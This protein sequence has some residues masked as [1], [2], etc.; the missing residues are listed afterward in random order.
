MPDNTFKTLGFGTTAIHA[1]QKPDPQY[2]ALA[3]P[4]YQTSTFCFSTVEEGAKKFAHELPGYVYSRG[5]NPTTAALQEKIAIL[6]K[7]EACFVTASG[8][9]AVGS[10]LLALLKSG[11]HV[12]CGECVYGCTH[13]VLNSVLPKFGITTT[14]TDTADLERIENSLRPNTRVILFETPTN[15][16][17]TLTDIKAVSA[18]AHKRDIKVV[19]DNTFAPPP[20]QFPLELGADIVV[21][22][23]TKYLNGHGDVIGGAIVGKQT[24]IE[25]IGGSF[26]TKING[27]TPSPFDS[28]LTL[29]GLQTLELR[30]QRHCE[31]GM[32]LAKYLASLACVERVNYPGLPSHPQ[33]AL[34]AR[35]MHGL[36]GGMLSFE[37]K[38]GLSGLTGFE[39]CKRVLNNLKIASIAVSL[40]DPATLVQHPAS[41]T[42]NN[43][44]QE[45]RLAAG[46]SDG[47]I[48]LSAGLENT[49]DIL[50]DFEQA[51]S[52]LRMR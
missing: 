48:R 20:L 15:P 43:V 24:D 51:F 46:I 28:F 16:T 29:R 17:M 40:G 2:G 42:H 35:Q 4:I 25:M 5:G 22:S 14:F 27:T 45:N 44:S 10:V 31:N 52:A 37:L 26:A 11:D 47:L 13:M 33:H 18:L 9:G 32:A 49:D 3:T 50:A 1:G 30:M 19:V 39:A 34:A 36:Y 21:H 41:M 12:V 23:T 38:D 8:M 7:G 6:E